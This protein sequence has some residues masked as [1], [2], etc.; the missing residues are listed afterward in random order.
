[1]GSLKRLITDMH[2][3]SLWQ[4]LSIYLVGSWI[5]LQ[6]VQAV[7]HSAGLPDWTPGLCFALLVLGLPMVLATAFVQEGG[8]RAATSTDASAP[9]AAPERSA[10]PRPTAQLHQRVF[11]WR[12]A[13]VGGVLAFALLGASVAAY[14]GL[15]V[16]GVGPAASL[17]AQGVFTERERVILAEFDNAT[18]DS[19]LGDVVTTALR[20]DLMQ[21][22]ALAVVEPAEIAAAL[23]RMRRPTGGRLDDDV[24]LE[25]AER[26]G[27]K[28][29]L[30]GN[31][32]ALGTGWVITATLRAP[33]DGRSL[34]AFRVTARNA[35]EVIDAVDRLSRQVREK[36]G[37]SLRVIR[38]GLPLG[39]VTTPSLEAL[40]LYTE[41]TTAG[42]AGEY[43]RS[44]E[45]LDAAVAMDTAFAMAWRNIGVALYNR[46][47]NR[48]RQVEAFTRA[49][50]H[51]DRL[52]ERE[53]HLAAAAYYAYVEP[54]RE[55]TIQ[56]YRNVLRLDPDDPTALNNL[57]NELSQ[58][59][60]LEEAL[61]QYRRAAALPGASSAAHRNTILNELMLGRIDEA[62]AALVDYRR[63]FPEDPLGIEAE[64][65]IEFSAGDIGAAERLAR[66]LADSVAL[67]A[68]MRG[69]GYA[70]LGMLS[71][72]RGRY[73]DAIAWSD[74]YARVIDAAGGGGGQMPRLIRLQFG[75]EL[76]IDPARLVAQAD[77]FVESEAWRS[78]PAWARAYDLLISGYAALGQADRVQRYTAE[79]EAGVSPAMRGVDYE[80]NAVAR[81]GILALRG[82]DAAAAAQAL[83]AARAGRNCSYCYRGYLADAY[84]QLGRIDEAIALHESSLRETHELV[85]LGV[86]DRTVA[87]QRLGPL[88]E[89]A[90]RRDEAL[91]AYARFVE[92][93]RDADPHL[94]SRVQA[95][96]RAIERLRGP[97]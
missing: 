69:F 28:A 96:R 63:A 79:Y 77:A 31:V 15:R 81:L 54:D 41:A 67:P 34:A 7:T 60:R 64:A 61:G 75:A 33:P 25:I 39:Q 71:F 46:R 91:A 57:A 51:R 58:S 12:N 66:R 2:R 53:H 16:L 49:W 26:E 87:I 23:R 88:Y 50:Q 72:H 73:E 27:I 70:N 55:R 65:W 90:G 45:L 20:I 93:W 85:P 92:R 97:G 94:Q 32:G 47:I 35:D 80:H 83:E 9:S 37:E 68:I 5:A 30:H 89:A 62:R 95:A 24:A 3:R 19:V 10:E 84:E 11:T 6:V 4:V 14:S 76:G 43:E 18:A 36:A 1:M 8:P 21:S 59:G 82:G 17:R 40:R 74:R 29:V 44:L 42:R 52:T 86:L 56:A 38:A 22:G 48:V 78:A 13:V